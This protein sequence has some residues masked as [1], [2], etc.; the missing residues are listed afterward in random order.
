MYLQSGCTRNV[1]YYTPFPLYITRGKGSKIWDLNG[2]EL[3]DLNFNNITLI[4]GH[5]YP[6][7][8]EAI[9]KQLER[10]T[11]LG[12]PTGL[13]VELAEEILRRLRGAD[14]IHFTP[15]ETEAI[16]Q[17]LRL[18]RSY[19]GRSSPNARGPTTASGTP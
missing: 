7:V 1:L 3:V 8:V 9:K 16:M 5:N 15:S 17:A 6:S 13:E 19:T 10:G 11:V 4:L 18:A 12:A 2:N 14:K